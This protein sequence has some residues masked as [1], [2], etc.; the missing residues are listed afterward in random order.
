[1][2]VIVV[3][4]EEII[5]DGIVDTVREVLPDAE[6]WSFQRSREALDFAGEHKVDVAFLDIEM[7]EYNGIELAKR[8]K[9]TNYRMNII[10]TTSYSQYTGEAMK[11]HASG[12]ILKP[13]TRDG[14]LYEIENLRSPVQDMHSGRLLIQ[15]FGNFEVFCGQE[16]VR[17]Q[18]TKTRELLAYL[19]D[20]RGAL[21]SNK[22]LEAV[23]WED[24][25]I[26]QKSSY[27]K[28]I[29][30]DLIDTLM[31]TG[32]KDVLSMQWGKIGIIKE[33][34]SC[35]YYDWIEGKPYAINAFQ[36]EYMTQYSWSEETAGWLTSAE[37]K[38]SDGLPER[39]I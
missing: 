8:L 36:G 32:H 7:P 28:R 20:R 21:C 22:E 35:D 2:R 9:T 18:Y 26:G 34:V 27:L 38:R 24:A 6:L 15:T 23:L 29:K 39:R 33:K 31:K 30:R 1:M 13:V 17:F 12:Y 4:D 19:V 11:L 3:D 16:P 25:G 14:V 10:F 37:E 5:L